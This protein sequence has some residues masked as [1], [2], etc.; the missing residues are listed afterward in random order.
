VK[1]G[2]VGYIRRGKFYRLFN[3]LL[4]ADHPSHHNIPLPEH[5]EPLVPSVPNHIDRGTLRP[6]HFCSIGVTA[7][8]ER[9][10]VHAVA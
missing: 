7:E 1:V 9:E 10:D 4:S 3:A 6:D 5:H 8:I 2:D